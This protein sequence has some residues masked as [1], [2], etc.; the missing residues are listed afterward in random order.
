[1]LYIMRHGKT[2]WNELHK[3]QGHTDIPFNANGIA[4]AE[5]A[6]K[7]YKNVH[8]DVC[9]CSPL[10][11]ARQTADIILRDRDE[12]VPVI[13]DDRLIEMGF[14]EYEGIQGYTDDAGYNVNTL[15]HNPAGYIPDKGAESLDE[16]FARTG[17]FL[18]TIIKPELAK[19]K[20]ILIVGHG[21]MN[22]SIICQVRGKSYEHFWDE[23]IENCK[24]KCL[25]S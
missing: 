15:F 17:E 16:L 10:T 3:L 25:I 6:A 9:Y 22:S 19:G 24:L 13:I 7:E 23:A 20:D 12:K 1:M 14:G 18:D 11:R 8:F 21:A 5:N 2:D 4:M